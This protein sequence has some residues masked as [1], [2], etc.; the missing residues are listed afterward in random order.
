MWRIIEGTGGKYEVNENGEVFNKESGKYAKMSSASHDG[1]VKCA[2]Y[3]N[4][5]ARTIALHR[6][7]AQTFIPNPDNKPQVHHIDGN[8][9]NNKVSNLEWVTPKEHGAK[10][11]E[12]QKKRFLDT[13]KNNKLKRSGHTLSHSGMIKW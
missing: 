3:V 9:E 11:N 2:L 1:Y 6:L 8:K 13:Y 12:D 4:G 10:M 7:V 5:T